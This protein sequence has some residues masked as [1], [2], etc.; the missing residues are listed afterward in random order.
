MMKEDAEAG[1]KGVAAK[2][3]LSCLKK[4]SILLHFKKKDYYLTC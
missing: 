2:Q 4:I 1:L 3:Q